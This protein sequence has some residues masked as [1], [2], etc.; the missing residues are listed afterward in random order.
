[1]K[2]DLFLFAIIITTVWTT[3][4][5]MN[6]Q[7]PSVKFEI[8]KDR[9]LEG[10]SLVPCDY[11]DRRYELPI[12]NKTL[13]ILLL[14]IYQN[15]SQKNQ[16]FYSLLKKFGNQLHLPQNPS[17]TT[18][19]TSKDM[20]GGLLAHIWQV[21]ERVIITAEQTRCCTPVA[22]QNNI[23]YLCHS[24]KGGDEEFTTEL[25]DFSRDLPIITFYDFDQTLLKVRSIL[26]EAQR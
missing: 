18:R 6:P 17:G 25:K 16:E 4:C 13:L 23:A 9:I 11:D 5:A 14:E 24:F 8:K 10:R 7:A 3:I 22:I 26:N 19:I 2:R 12:E 20:N 15:N 1:M 21:G